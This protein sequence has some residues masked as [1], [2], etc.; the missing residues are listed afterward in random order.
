MGP[1][2][3]SDSTLRSEV[4]PLKGEVK[5]RR[6]ASVLPFTDAKIIDEI[7]KLLCVVFG[8]ASLYSH[9]LSIHR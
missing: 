4:G 7:K 9:H 1:D 6:S 2:K 3:L 8:V 5:A